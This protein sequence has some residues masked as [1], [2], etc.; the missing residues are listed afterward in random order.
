MKNYGTR[1]ELHSGIWIGRVTY[2][3]LLLLILDSVYIKYDAKVL[4][5]LSTHTTIHIKCICTS[6][7]SRPKYIFISAEGM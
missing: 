1:S 5:A 4:F 6:A 2:N 3:K 7:E